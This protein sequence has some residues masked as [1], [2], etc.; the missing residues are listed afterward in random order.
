VLRRMLIV[1]CCVR[2]RYVGGDAGG[3]DALERW[4]DEGESESGSEAAKR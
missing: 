2:L 1:A 4:S 3:G